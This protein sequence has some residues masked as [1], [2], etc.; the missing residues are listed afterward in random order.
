MPWFS[1][2]LSI[3]ADD[4]DPDEVT[5]L[6]VVKPDKV[7]RKGVT[8]LT[9]RGRSYVPEFGYWSIVL[10][11]E[12]T[13]EWDVEIA[14]GMLLDR[15]SA[16]SGAWRQARANAHARMFVGLRLDGFNRRFK[17]CPELM[18]RLAELGVELDFDIYDAQPDP[19]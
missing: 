3:R 2:T 17:L 13:T 16:S 1:I 6:L 18:Q 11:G 14:I 10:R 4:L 12:D 8:T 5:R 15:V 9:R 19:D 7:V